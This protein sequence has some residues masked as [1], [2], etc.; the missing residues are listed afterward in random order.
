M[1]NPLAVTMELQWFSLGRDAVVGAS[2]STSMIISASA[3]CADK[4]NRLVLL[5]SAQAYRFLRLVLKDL[6]RLRSFFFCWCTGTLADAPAL[7]VLK[8]FKRF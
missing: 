5:I 6:N 2:P 7:P 8:L 4:Q 3:K 1:N